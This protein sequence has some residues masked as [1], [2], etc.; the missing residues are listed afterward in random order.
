MEAAEGAVVTQH[1]RVSLPATR[2]SISSNLDFA[3][4]ILY[5]K[6]NVTNKQCKKNLPYSN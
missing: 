3:K 2:L 6:L 1:Y 4:R 5:L